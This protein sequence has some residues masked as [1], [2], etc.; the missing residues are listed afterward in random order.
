[1]PAQSRLCRGFGCALSAGFVGG[2]AAANGQ[3][4]TSAQNNTLQYSLGGVSVL[5]IVFLLFQLFKPNNC[6]ISV[7]TLDLYKL[8][9]NAHLI[10]SDSFWYQ[11]NAADSSSL[12]LKLRL[13]QNQNGPVDVPVND[14]AGQNLYTCTIQVHNVDDFAAIQKR[15]AGFVG[16]PIDMLPSEKEFR[17]T[18]D[19]KPSEKASANGIK[20]TPLPQC[21]FSEGN[22]VQKFIAISTNNRKFMY[23]VPDP[24]QVTAADVEV[25]VL[26]EFKGPPNTGF[27]SIFVNAFAQSAGSSFQDLKQQLASTNDVIRVQARRFLEANFIQYKSDVLAE[28]F[29]VQQDNGDYLASL[30]SGL[31]AGI[32]SAAMPPSSLSPGRIRDLGAVLPYVQG[33]E[34][35]I[36]DLNGHPSDA[37]KQQARRLI[38]RFPFDVFKDRYPR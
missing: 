20:A 23:G 21:F 38:S 36:V 19:P 7:T 27:P 3:L 13:E 18:F 34:D 12:V 26:A 2:A 1:M 11:L 16:V 10:V 5:V 30:I 28:I 35:Q 29:N 24:T 15:Y 8:P 6:N 9:P 22:P 33:H 17:L 32:D 37:V 14:A 25:P 31:I 4:G